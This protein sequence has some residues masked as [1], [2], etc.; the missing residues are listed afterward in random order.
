M[1]SI[2]REIVTKQRRLK[3]WVKQK[4][5]DNYSFIHINKCGGTTIERVLNIP[6]VHDTAIQRMRKIGRNSWDR[7]FTFALI[8]NPYARVVSHFNYRVKTNQ[9]N[10]R[11]PLNLNEW[12]Q[13]AYG[14]KN[15]FWYDNPLMFQPCFFWVSHNDK[16]I[17]DKIIKLEE[18]DLQWPQ[19]AQRLNVSIKHLPIYN[20]TDY[21]SSSNPLVLLDKE[22]IAIVD[23]IFDVDFAV[24][25]YK[26][27]KDA[28]E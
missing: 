25:G 24:F 11:N 10:M 3:F 2:A 21:G 1:A 9:T 14:K 16:I 26:K 18:L 6:K 20:S 4:W 13:E 28:G 5:V 15:P 27:S 7:R 19:M 22:S 23:E 8:R 17:V 12:V